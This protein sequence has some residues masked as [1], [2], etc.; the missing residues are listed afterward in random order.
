MDKTVIR[1]YK[2]KLYT[3]EQFKIFVKCG[4][5][6]ESQYQETTGIEYKPQTS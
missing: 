2:A 5:I 6:T 1:F 4:W 3:D